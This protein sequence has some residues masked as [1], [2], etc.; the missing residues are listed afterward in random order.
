MSTG[1]MQ[2]RWGKW[3]FTP[4]QDA[5]IFRIYREVQPVGRNSAVKD[6]ARRWGF[7][8]WKVSRRAR[9]IGAY[10]PRIKEL[11]WSA[12]EL[13]ILELNQM[14]S[15]NVIQ[16]KLKAQGFIR[17]ATGIQ[18]K[19]KRLEL[20]SKYNPTSALSVAACFGVDVHAI[21]RWIRQGLLKATHK[22]TQRTSIQGGDEWVIKEQDIRRFIISNIGVIDI[23]KVDKFWFV[24]VLAGDESMD[25]QNTSGIGEEYFDEGTI[26]LRA[27]R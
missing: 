18:L 14:Y 21:T 26:G 15:V 24:A 23:R 9:D 1:G 4:S 8:R 6:L 7:P 19:R 11:P 2:G 27:I 25:I 3:R 20:R 17:S 12:R 22:G 16:R 10:E 13:H 5:E